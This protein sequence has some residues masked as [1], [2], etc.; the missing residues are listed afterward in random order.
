M[1]YKQGD[2][3]TS[4]G[5]EGVIV[6]HYHGSMYEIRLPGGVC[7]VDQADIRPRPEAPSPCPGNEYGHFYR[8]HTPGAV[9]CSRCGER[10]PDHDAA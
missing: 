7:C 10:R 2:R 3:I 4:S 6:R 8:V 9:W 5:F 1:K